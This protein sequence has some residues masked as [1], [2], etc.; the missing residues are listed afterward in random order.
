MNRIFFKIS[1]LF[2]LL[3]FAGISVSAQN[4]NRD[5]EPGF[6]GPF[7]WD[8]FY[9]GGGLGLQ[10]GDV[11]LI[12]VSPLI[13][14]NITQQLSVGLSP[15]YKYYSYKDYYLNREISSNIFGAA[16]FSRFDII[17]GLF[18]HAE[19]EQLYVRYND[20]PNLNYEPWS[21]FVG[22]GYKQSIGGRGF[23]YILVLWNLN[24][25]PESPYA[26]PVFR[27]GFGV[28]L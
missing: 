25:T 16:L 18:A 15:T 11:T 9:F 5:E 10:I 7:S 2:I 13:G 24:E 14:Y 20:Y 23:A 6:K 17:Y 27:V 21:F 12:D 1:A 3:F 19:Y 8:R 4:F 22:G 26:N 28:G